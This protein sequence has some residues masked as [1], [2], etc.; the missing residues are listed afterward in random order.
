[1]A[2]LIKLAVVVALLLAGVWLAMGRP[3]LGSAI[4][5]IDRSVATRATTKGSA[6]P[7]P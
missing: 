7:Q 1:M 2:A 6:A 4:S 5:A 3:T